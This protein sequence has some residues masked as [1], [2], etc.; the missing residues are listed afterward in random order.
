[1][2]FMG[3]VSFREGMYNLVFWSFVGSSG[4]A[5]NYHDFSNK[6]P[7]APGPMLNEVIQI[8]FC[9]ISFTQKISATMDTMTP[10]HFL[11]IL[12]RKKV[13]LKFR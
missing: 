3:Y 5:K 8:S 4:F 7:V 11:Q 6:L 13:G 10:S 12:Q 1:M 9:G 2:I